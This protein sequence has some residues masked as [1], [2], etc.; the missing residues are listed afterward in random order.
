F[1]SRLTPPGAKRVAIS[2]VGNR[3]Q[4]SKARVQVLPADARWQKAARRRGIEMD[5]DGQ[6]HRARDVACRRGLKRAGGRTAESQAV[7]PR[8]PNPSSTT[9]NVTLEACL[10]C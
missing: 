8:S 5:A 10:T 1:V 3:R 6:R 7:R 9:D 4:R 2:Q